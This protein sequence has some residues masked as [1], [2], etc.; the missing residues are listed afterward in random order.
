MPLEFYDDFVRI[1]AEEAAHFQSWARRLEE[2]GSYYGEL[3][4]HDGLWAD[5][6]ST[7]DDLLARLALVH[8]V[9]EARGLDVFPASRQVCMCQYDLSKAIVFRGF[10]SPRLG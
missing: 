6:H 9:H 2:L 1:A 10:R 3:P 4:C 8:M 5:A 7:R